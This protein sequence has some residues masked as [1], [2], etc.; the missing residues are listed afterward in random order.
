MSLIACST[1]TLC[2]VGANY[3]MF[4]RKSP[5]RINRAYNRCSVLEGRSTAR[6][7]FISLKTLEESVGE[8][9]ARSQFK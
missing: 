3:T 9:L 6:A 7:N 1:S 2:N 5:G 8:K 4:A